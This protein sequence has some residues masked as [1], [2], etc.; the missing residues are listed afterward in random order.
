MSWEHVVSC[1]LFVCIRKCT[2][3]KLQKQ[4]CDIIQS[5][6]KFLNSFS[7]NTRGGACIHFIISLRSLKIVSSITSSKKQNTWELL[8]IK[9]NTLT[10]MSAFCYP[11][12]F[13]VQISQSSFKMS[14]LRATPWSQGQK[15]RWSAIYLRRLL[16]PKL[17][18]TIQL[19]NWNVKEA[20]FESKWILCIWGLESSETWLSL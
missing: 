16:A 17:K 6:L 1:I 15:P 5:N 19:Y 18:P 7:C 4:I 12:Y 2:L 14:A 8:K 11:I 3:K 13:M 20:K 10:S 9:R